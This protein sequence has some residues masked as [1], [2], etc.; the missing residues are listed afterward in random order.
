MKKK[1]GLA[2]GA[3]VCVILLGFGIYKTDASQQNPRLSVDD[4]RQMVEAQY[5]GEITEIELDTTMN[6]SVYEVEV[7]SQGREYEIKL[8]GQ[9]G[10]ILN[11]KERATK[12]KKESVV[13]N[14]DDSQVKETTPSND[15]DVNPE[16]NTDQS[17]QQDKNSKN[18]GT[19]SQSDSN[20]QAE[21]P[22]KK[23]PKKPTVIDVNQAIA[24]AK[25]QFNGTVI[26]AGL[27]EDDGRLIYEIELENGQEEVEIE[28]DAY[29]GEIL[30]IEIDRDDD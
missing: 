30:L 12:A 2:I 5:P 4:I 22:A 9:T 20:Q 16:K 23:Q 13:L 26:E 10:E 24:I 1:M 19:Q 29:T 7:I 6:K 14:D 11:L 18:N 28:V 8:D 25:S 15:Q 27:D 3:V 17:Q 21:T